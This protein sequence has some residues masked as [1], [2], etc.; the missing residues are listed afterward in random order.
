GSFDDEI[1]MRGESAVPKDLIGKT[2][3]FMPRT[4]SHTFLHLF[5]EQHGIRKS[6][7]NIKVINP[8][9]MPDALI[10]GEVDA[11]SCWKPHTLHARSAM[12]ELEIS[13]SFFQNNGFY[14]SEVVL[15]SNKPFLVKNKD[16]VSKMLLALRDAKGYFDENTDEAIA[17]SAHKLKLENSVLKKYW[18]EFQPVLSAINDDYMRNIHILSEWIKEND[19]EFIT[20]ALPDYSDYI[21]NR[22]FLTTP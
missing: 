20:K 14:A 4:G 17:I 10:K 2:I 15:A 7:I 16:T 5:L 6:D 18:H 1:L 22:F 3:A 11:I 8:Q 13:Y 19:T 9:S 12:D 21:D